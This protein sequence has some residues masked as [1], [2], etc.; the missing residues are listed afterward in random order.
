MTATGNHPEQDTSPNQ[1]PYV[2]PVQFPYSAE[3]EID[4]FEL[5]AGLWRRRIFIA[6]VTGAFAI[7]SIVWVMLLATPSYVI[8]A[9]LLPPT[10]ADLAPLRVQTADAN[11][12][13]VLSPP[14]P[15]SALMAFSREINS[16]E[17]QRRVFKTELASHVP[18]LSWS[19]EERD[20]ELT[21]DQIFID[22]FLPR[23]TFFEEKPAKNE[24]PVSISV[25]FETQDPAAGVA[26][27]ANLVD[28]ANE[29]A[30]SQAVT[31]QTNSVSET[32]IAL[33]SD[34]ETRI[35]QVKQNDLMEIQR[36]EESNATE[37]QRLDYKIEA[38]RNSNE[39]ARQDRIALLQENLVIAQRLGIE[40]PVDFE[41][42]KPASI[43]QGEELS[44]DVNG[45]KK[46]LYFMGVRL[47]EAEI[48]AL[49]S[50]KDNDFTS[51][52]L[53]SLQQQRLLLETDPDIEKL[54]ARENYA[55]F[56]PGADAIMLKISALNAFL[57][58]DLTQVSFI[59][60]D[61]PPV[62]PSRPHS[63][64]KRLIVAAATLAGGMLAVLMALILNIRD[65]RLARRPE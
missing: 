11:L 61:L 13:G 33:A 37:K 22:D 45:G 56:A 48:D 36:L 52:E 12:N 46:P 43:S 23:L 53:R 26:I 60:I 57:G 55:A 10:L 40:D 16:R 24:P 7:L 30:T 20:P 39:M 41:D 47:L 3:D 65:E 21:D 6:L 34:L 18:M 58:R 32:V 54:K 25:E 9:R 63:P 29:V 64:N 49:S 59:R 28:L 5:V 38:L 27:V 35:K 1:G 2:Y 62:I 51:S 15:N 19:T 42:L 17:L 4:L 31:D 50:R 8:S 44:V 14:N